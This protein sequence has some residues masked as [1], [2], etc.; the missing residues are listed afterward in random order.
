MTHDLY[1]WDWSD[2][3]DTAYFYFRTNNPKRLLMVEYWADEDTVATLA[4]YFT[5]EGELLEDEDINL[6][7]EQRKEYA[8]FCKRK[9]K[10][11]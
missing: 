11:D 9:I 1:R 5:I 6:N 3:S 2:F 7:E 10:E 4:Q 8:E